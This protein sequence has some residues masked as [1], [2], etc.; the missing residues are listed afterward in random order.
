MADPGMTTTSEGMAADRS[1]GSTL[2]RAD[3]DSQCV[4]THHRVA[5]SARGQNMLNTIDV[6]GEAPF[7]V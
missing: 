4:T 5:R 2:P 3:L 7:S 6:L 1:N